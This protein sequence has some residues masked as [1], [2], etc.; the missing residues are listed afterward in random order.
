MRPTNKKRPTETQKQEG[1]TRSK[2]TKNAAKTKSQDKQE[3]GPKEAGKGR[4]QTATTQQPT[5]SDRVV[6][7]L[8]EAAVLTSN[9]R[10]SVL[11]AAG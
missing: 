11:S 9:S 5:H 1:K 10:P 8:H 4:T 3:E 2:P 7:C 6:L